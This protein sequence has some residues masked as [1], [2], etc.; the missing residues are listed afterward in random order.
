MEFTSS[1]F[2]Y[3]LERLDSSRPRHVCRRSLDNSSVNIFTKSLKCLPRNEIAF[4]T[5]L[6]HFQNWHCVLDTEQWFTC[7]RQRG[8]LS[9]A[10]CLLLFRCLKISR[11]KSKTVRMPETRKRNWLLRHRC[12]GARDTLDSAASMPRAR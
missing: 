5:I 7:L 4:G 12:P 11:S 2:A 8:N 10:I 1:E 9:K 3:D 6:N